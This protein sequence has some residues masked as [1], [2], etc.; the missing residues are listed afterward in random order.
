[1]AL[2]LND[3]ASV[4]TQVLNIV[5]AYNREDCVS[6]LR[7]RDWLETI[8]RDLVAAGK[9]IKRPPIVPGDPNEAVDLRRKRALALMGRLLH[10]IPDERSGRT[11]EQQ[12]QWLLAHMLEF[13]RREE[14]APWWEYFR[15]RGLSDE[16]LLEERCAIAGLEFLKRIGGTLVCPI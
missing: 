11:P 13:H 2:E 16:E 8:R 5:E 10:D 15:L 12:A 9:E 14:K 4:A 6:A 3:V 7:L 1:H